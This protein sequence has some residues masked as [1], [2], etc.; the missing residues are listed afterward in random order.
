MTK[1][2]SDSQ[3]TILYL[4]IG[5][6]AL[7]AIGMPFAEYQG[8]ESQK[9]A[10]Y[11][12]ILIFNALVWMIYFRTVD[13]SVR[14]EH[15]S[16]QR[17]SKS[18]RLHMSDIRAVSP[19]PFGNLRPV[20]VSFHEPTPF[21]KLVMFHDGFHLFDIG[22]NETGSFLVKQHKKYTEQGR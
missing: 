18:V 12:F 7:I 10:M 19:W 6:G 2:S 3:W 14:G 20:W 16:I 5:V 1:L 15:V 4:F 11:V 13:F 8:P 17:G 22:K 9:P 21:G